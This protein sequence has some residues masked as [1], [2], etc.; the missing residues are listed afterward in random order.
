MIKVLIVEDD[1]MV[2]HLN[3]KYVENVEGYQVVDIANN[4]EKALKLLRTN[5]IDLVVLDVYM[6]KLDGIS[7]LKEMRKRFFMTD[8]ILVTAAKEADNID[9]V[10]KLGA[11]DYLIKPFEYERLKKAL[12]SYKIRYNLLRNNTPINQED[13]DK[14]TKQ[15]VMEVSKDKLE[16]GLHNKTLERIRNFMRANRECFYSAEEIAKKMDLSRVT[17]RRYL[18]YLTSIGEIIL[19]IEYGSVGRPTHLYKY[20]YTK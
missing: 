18:E 17:I 2:A 7:L 4:G 14:I 19:E 15:N 3:K 1:P 5:K 10:L 13:I 11:V 12:D 20:N 8:V 16:K 9:S 6:P